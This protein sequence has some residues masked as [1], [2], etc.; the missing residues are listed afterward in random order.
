MTA[1]MD[2]SSQVHHAMEYKTGHHHG[3][4]AAFIRLFAASARSTNAVAK[5]TETP[6]AQGQDFMG[7][8]CTYVD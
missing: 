1:Q 3:R 2:F 6:I 8:Y 5:H 4:R 7:F